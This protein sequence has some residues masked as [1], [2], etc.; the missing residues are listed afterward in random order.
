MKTRGAGGRP[1]I[2][3]LVA[4]SALS[5]LAVVLL[6]R[7]RAEPPAR[8]AAGMIALG[9]R[10]CGEGQVLEGERCQGP[11]ARCAIGME[12]TPSGCVAT[13]RRVPVEGGLLR[14]GPGD[15]EAQG[16]ISAREAMIAP[17]V[18]DALEIDES[19]YDACAR[20][21][22][23]ARLPLSGEPGRARSG[24][25]EEEAQAHCRWAGGS[26]PTRDQLAFAA[27]G[28]NGRRYAWGDT[29]AVCRRAAWG[30]VNGP[31]AEGALGPELTGAHPD[32]ASPE[33][34][35]DL[36]GNVAEWTLPEPANALVTE[37][38]GGSFADGAANGI[39]AWQR[40]IVPVSTRSPEIGARC[41]YA[42]PGG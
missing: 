25:T 15:W 1:R 24:L 18:I 20:E 8:C 12:A 39:R 41:V 30:L 22:A 11:P 28:K 14:I 4:G 35:L 36:A 2:A 9:A 19:R 33:G 3:L 7:S 6:A 21:G 31:C 10:C 26:L 5:L 34:A 37:V 42:A 16:V 38:R 17:F 27:A 29:G 23:C 40:R 32:G 13:P